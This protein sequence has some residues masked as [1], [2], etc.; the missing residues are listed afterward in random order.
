V[1]SAELRPPYLHLQGARHRGKWP[2]D[3]S[4]D[5]G[6][7]GAAMHRLLPQGRAAPAPERLSPQ[8]LTSDKIDS[9]CHMS[10]GRRKVNGAESGKDDAKQHEIMSRRNWRDGNFVVNK[11]Q[12]ANDVPVPFAC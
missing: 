11:H 8:R 6:G 7:S 9:E 10:P 3:Y 1:C 5:Q 2:L 12:K 4:A